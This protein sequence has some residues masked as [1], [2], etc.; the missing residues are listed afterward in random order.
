M[1]RPHPALLQL[2]LAFAAL[3][4]GCGPDGPPAE[5]TPSQPGAAVGSSTSAADAPSA[6]AAGGAEVDRAGLERAGLERA[7]LDRAVADDPRVNFLLAPCAKWEHYDVDTADVGAILSEMLLHGDRDAL[8]RG[9]EEL[10]AR[11]AEG[12]AIVARVVDRYL[13]DKDGYGPLRNAVEVCERSDAPQ[14]RAVLLRLLDCAFEGVAVQAVQ[15]LGKHGRPEDLD[16]VLAVFERASLENKMK[17]ATT[18]HAIDPVR[19]SQ[20]YLDWM[21]S[22][23]AQSHWDMFCQALARS[24]DAQ[25][26]RRAREF[27]ERA[28]ERYHALLSAPAARAGDSEA[29]EFLRDQARAPE[30]WRRELAIAALSAAGLADELAELA[31]NDPN[32]ELRLRAINALSPS[33]PKLV[34]SLRAGALSPNSL[35]ASTCLGL[36]IREGD[37][38]AIDRTLEMLAEGSPQDLGLAMGA[39]EPALANDPALCERTLE[40]LARRAPLEGAVSLAERV[41]ILESIARVPL[42]EAAKLLRERAA[43][44]TGEVKGLPARRWLLRLV[45]NLGESGQRLAAA[46]LRTTSDPALRLDLLEALSVRSTAFARAELLRLA[47]SDELRPLEL[48]FV[49]DRLTLMASVESAAGIL[50]RATLRVVDPDVRRAMQ[51]LMWRSFPGPR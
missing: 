30:L 34:E 50:K 23:F 31:T 43:V 5:A 42:A 17:I 1:A 47:E 4:A 49:A 44:E 37:R 13:N 32:D 14:A 24:G 41:S 9:R 2:W 35:I 28:P 36:L 12:L 51:C 22:G 8:R 3:A 6:T 46:E 15:A 7:R 48:L 40:I 20:I 10:A 26:A 45:G 16:A 27:R 39:L 33:S 11:G 38:M 21:T 18:M 29:L 19:A 25:V